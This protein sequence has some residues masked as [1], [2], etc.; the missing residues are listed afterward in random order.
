MMAGDKIY[1]QI[2]LTNPNIDASEIATKPYY[3]NANWQDK[4]TWYSQYIGQAGTSYA[5]WNTDKLDKLYFPGSTRKTNSFITDQASESTRGKAGI[6]STGCFIASTAMVLRNMGKTMNGYD[7]R[8][9]FTGPLYADPYTVTLANVQRTG[10]EV[11]QDS[12]T[13][14]YN[15]STKAVDPVSVVMSN[16]LS[17]TGFNAKYNAGGTSVTGTDAQK[18]ATLATAIAGNNKRGIIALLK[19]GSRTHYIV[20]VGDRGSSYAAKDRFII[21]DPGGQIPSRGD[22]VPFSSS[23]SSLTSKYTFSNI[24]TYWNIKELYEEDN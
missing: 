14:R 3:L 24:T 15:L 1:V 23:F 19:T 7:F 2:Y 13:G 10:K 12:G 5:Q 21:C 11:V 16:I 8:T 4:F 17:P 20:I 22:N 6:M 18:A 9:G